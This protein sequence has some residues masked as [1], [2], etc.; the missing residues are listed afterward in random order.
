MIELIVSVLD[1]PVGPM[2]IYESSDYGSIDPELAKKVM[3]RCLLSFS[4]L[5]GPSSQLQQAD[6]VLSF[7]EME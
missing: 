2:S 4:L 7:S 3:L 5:E 1:T 6:A